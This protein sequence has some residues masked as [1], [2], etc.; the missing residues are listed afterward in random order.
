MGAAGP[1][2]HSARSG[3]TLRPEDPSGHLR[4]QVRVEYAPLSFFFQPLLG[5]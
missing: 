4:L 1:L 2:A 3:T 5:T